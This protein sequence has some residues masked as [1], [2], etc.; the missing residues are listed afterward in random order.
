MSTVARSWGG[1]LSG[2]AVGSRTSAVL[3]LPAE[4]NLPAQPSSF[5]GRED[6][7]GQVLGALAEGRFVT[8]VGPGGVGKTR[9]ALRAAEIASCD[10]ACR[11]YV[12]LAGVDG[13]HVEEAVLAALPIAGARRRH[14]A[15]PGAL[16][17]VV[18]N[19][20]HV[21]AECAAVIHR[22]VCAFPEISVLATSRQPL[23]V[24]G[25]HVLL[26]EP[27]TLLESDDVDCAVAGAN[28]AVRLF[29]ERARAARP[30]FELDDANASAVAEICRRVDGL[31]LA[32][33]LAAARIA[34]LSPAEVLARLAEPFRLLTDR[35]T[36]APERHRSL[37]AALEWGHALL[38]EPEAAVF[39]RLSVFATAWDLEAAEAVCAGGAVSADD[40]LDLLTAL[41]AHSL[42][43]VERRGPQTRFRMLGTVSQFA[44]AKLAET[45]T[46]DGVAEKHARWYVARAERAAAERAGP[47]PERWLD[48]LEEDHAEFRAALRWARAHERSDIVL[49]LGGALSWFWETRGHL[50]E[51]V[52]WL[53]WAVEHKADADPELRARALRG[54]GVLTWLLGDAATAMPLVDEAVGLFRVAGNEE[55]ASGCVCASAFHVC[56]NPIHSL[57]AVEA[58][59]VRMRDLQDRGRL[60]RSLV[61]AGVAYFF[62]SDACRAKACFEECLALPRESVELEVVV[63]AHLGL[64]RVSVLSGDL[65]AAEGWLDATLELTRSS[66]DD[67]GH[68][69]A[70][71]WIGE[72]HRIRGDHGAARAAIADASR[73]ADDAGLP[74]ALARCHQFLGR[75]EASEGNLERARALLTRSLEAPG[76]TQ[77]S[78]HRVRSLQ[79]LAEVALLDGRAE[80]VGDLLDK[81]LSLAQGTGDRQAQGLAL[82][83]LAR[84]AAAAG[85]SDRASRFAHEA[86]Q[87]QERI[88]DVFGIINSLETLAELGAA[89][90]RSKVA[91]RLFGAAQTA[92]EARGCRRQL[93]D[94]P[95]QARR[96]P[97]V[98]ALLDSGAWTKAVS[99]GSHLSTPEAVSYAVKGW[100]SKDRPP[101]GWD[102][103]TRAERD[104]AN[105]VAE[106]MS[107]R[108]IG[109]RLLVSARTVETHLSHIYRK[110]PVANRRE[111]GR[112]T[113]ERSVAERPAYVRPTLVTHQ[114]RPRGTSP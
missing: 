20:E 56:E 35:S 108:E 54:A 9:L 47:N 91:A 81:A 80:G 55:E 72:I 58:D 65:V 103:L 77:L 44:A 70:L 112:A 102:S 19:C 104:I 59:L 75:L 69:A 1:P 26:V 63:D 13:A 89:S 107:N 90:G 18:D 96:L 67:D 4:G 45:D 93:L 92:R 101:I 53:R 21:H 64:G 7:L 23:E 12:E 60:A 66:G 86:L 31:P 50:H 24:A 68:S 41:V 97:R 98:A 61:N 100:G 15:D 87:V 6:E 88:S 22:L 110:V 16:L 11:A 62:V 57:P 14:L 105:L 84:L 38:T 36:V 76:A 37:E 8:L 99:E 73:L 52:E 109:L 79:A 85:D 10:Y 95:E 29:L 27:L 2:A 49:A 25:E 48:A 114:M 74:L 82:T 30:Q 71:C 106:G 78:Y 5:V 42:V 40:I 46:A 94:E 28:E 111:L 43:V 17:V 39:A 32:I 3:P 34:V 51:G 83:S 113:R 33:E